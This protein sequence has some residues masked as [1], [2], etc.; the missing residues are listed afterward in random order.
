[1]EGIDPGA[2]SAK[3][4]DAFT[5]AAFLH[6]AQVRKGTS[7][8]YVAHLMSVSALV[9][10]SGG[11]IEQAIAGLLHDAAEDQ[12]GA[13]TLEEIERRFGSAIA[14]IVSD[15]TDSWEEP[16]PPW[17]ARKEAYL[18]LLTGKEART[19]L[20]SL[21]DKTHNAEA[22]VADVRNIGPSVW[23]RFSGGAEG[24]VWYYQSLLA[25]FKSRIPGPLC[26][27]LARAV[28]EMSAFRSL[29]Q[30]SSK[31]PGVIAATIPMGSE[32]GD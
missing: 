25:I 2:A 31:R 7:I 28:D 17:R 23:D 8:P 4:S 24:T 10:E 22:I 19:L 16:K 21:A 11:D 3:L 26:S 15:C 27:R 14:K 12:G 6:A 20:V 5:Y 1:M 13:V 30:R 32:N 18:A 9:L 29:S